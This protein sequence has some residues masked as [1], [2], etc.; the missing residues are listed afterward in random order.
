MT[1][2]LQEKLVN[3]KIEYAKRF[4]VDKSYLDG[5][6]KA[7]LLNLWHNVDREIDPTQPLLVLLRIGNV[8]KGRYLKDKNMFI[9]TD[10]SMAFP[11]DVLKFMYLED[12]N[13]E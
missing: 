2:Q 5:Y 12:L 6:L 8:K 3:V 11:Q 7:Y 4:N 13:F 1:Q 10:D 9:F